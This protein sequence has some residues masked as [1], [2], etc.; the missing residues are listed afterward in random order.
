MCLCNFLTVGGESSGYSSAACGHLV[1][2]YDWKCGQTLRKTWRTQVRKFLH[3]IFALYVLENFSNFPPSVEKSK[4]FFLTV[5]SALR[6][7]CWRVRRKRSSCMLSR[8]SEESFTC[9]RAGTLY[10]VYAEFYV[11]TYNVLCSSVDMIPFLSI[12]YGTC[13]CAYIETCPK[14]PVITRWLANFRTPNFTAK[15]NWYTVCVRISA[16]IR[17]SC[18]SPRVSW[19]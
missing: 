15:C 13:G 12:V 6:R 16:D 8:W 10:T 11:H 14:F 3:L 1:W 2:G 9:P 19:R 7:S 4:I 17:S 5:F 18:C